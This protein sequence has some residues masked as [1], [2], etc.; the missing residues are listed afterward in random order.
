MRA[1]ARDVHTVLVGGEIVLQDGNPTRFDAEE[2]ELKLA[3][4]LNAQPHP[5]EEA[6]AV[7]HLL[8]HLEAHYREWGTPDLDP[9]IEYNSRR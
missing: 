1:Q 6:E 8:P 5:E 7:R 9:R 3:A 2:V 4:R